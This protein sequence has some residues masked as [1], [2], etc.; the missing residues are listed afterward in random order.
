MVSSLEEYTTENKTPIE[1]NF[2]NV[3]GQDSLTRFELQKNKKHNKRRKINKH[4]SYSSN[5]WNFLW[6]FIMRSK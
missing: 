5:F 3:V 2:E 4:V 6:I 1:N